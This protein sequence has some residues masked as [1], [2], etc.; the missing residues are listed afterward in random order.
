MDERRPRTWDSATT[1]R[2]VQKYTAL[3]RVSNKGACNAARSVM[4]N[5]GRN[6]ARNGTLHPSESIGRFFGGLAGGLSSGVGSVIGAVGTGLSPVFRETLGVFSDGGEVVWDGLRTGGNFVAQTAAPVI[7]TV[8]KVAKG[9]FDFFGDMGSTVIAIIG[10]VIGVI[11]V[12]VIIVV[13]VSNRKKSADAA[14]TTPAAAATTP[15]SI[16]T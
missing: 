8:G 2:P 3:I 5:A 4:R 14:P 16:K 12:I 11:I 9:A 13:V 6:A 1:G 7:N 15:A 10:G